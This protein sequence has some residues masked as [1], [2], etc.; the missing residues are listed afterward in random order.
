MDPIWKA[1][2]CGPWH[3]AFDGYAAA[4]TA[5]GTARLV[6]L[7]DWLRTELPGRLAGRPAQFV[8]LEELSW[9]TEWKMLRGVWRAHNLQLV[10]GNPSAE[11]ERLSAQALSAV[12]DPRRPVALLC[13]LA[14]VGPATASAVLA[15]GAPDV[16]PFFDEAVADQM[17]DLGPVAFS[18]AYYQQ[19]AEALR[20][21]A[22]SL[23]ACCTHTSWKVHDLDLA[24][25]AV[26]AQDKKTGK[27][28][29]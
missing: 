20:A 29:A 25:W 14:G 22:A 17:P 21:R 28:Y 3:G 5:Y 2:A 16:Y 19:Y 8:T 11:V 26:G 23:S 4:V 18:A 27:R 24:L 12:P 1:E 9:I 10:R 6:E 15:T 13:Q 7:D